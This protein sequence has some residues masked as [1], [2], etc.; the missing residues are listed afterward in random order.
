MYDTFGTLGHS[1]PFPQEGVALENPSPCLRSFSEE[2]KQA[3]RNQTDL[4]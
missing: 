3:D 4:F 1:S 2:E